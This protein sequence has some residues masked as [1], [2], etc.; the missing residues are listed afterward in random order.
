MSDNKNWKIFKR[1]M[2]NMLV[3]F[4]VPLFFL[5]LLGFIMLCI[6]YP[7]IA[8]LTF[9]GVICALFWSFWENAKTEILDEENG[10]D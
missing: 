6:A 8:L 4:A 7:Y 3:E 10:T 1:M 2:Y 9:V 5:G